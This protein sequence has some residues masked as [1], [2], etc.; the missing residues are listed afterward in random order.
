LF[1]KNDLILLLVIFGSMGLGIGLPASGRIFLPY[2]LYLVMLLLFFSF[3]KIE[4]I[5]ILKDMKKTTLIL[6]L[7]CFL[8]LIILP[9]GLFFITQMIWP[10]YALP[11]LLLSGISTGVV[12]PFISNLLTATTSLVLMMVVLSSL[13]VPFSLPA[14]VSLLA[15]QTIEISFSFMVKTLAMVVF[16]PAFAVLIA[17]PLIP[18]FLKKLERLQFPLSLV[19]F[20]F[21]N[22]GVFSKYS[23]FFM[24]NPMELTRT[25]F[26]AFLLS[27]IYHIAGFGVTWGMKR[28]DRLAGAISFANINN[29]LII[30]F[31][32]QFFGPLS[33]TLAVMYM[34]PF[35]TM[36]I[37]VRIMG[38]FLK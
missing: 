12:A 20:A 24:E 3:L 19:I 6:F 22:L 9:A 18:S 15:G 29:V 35:F 7:L 32:S 10:D 13:F 5:A 11:V 4:F 31:S 8:K 21:I 14:L 1:Q 23:S 30:V 33:P 34:L 2:P 26:L 17:R 36:I 38:N 27:I 28:G 16:L 37:P 25:T